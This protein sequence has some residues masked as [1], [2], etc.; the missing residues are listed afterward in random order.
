MLRKERE[1]LWRR[2]AEDMLRKQKAA[3]DQEEEEKHT[4]AKGRSSGDFGR[5][6]SGSRRIRERR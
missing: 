1:A 3:L 5:F 2:Y 6:S 4:D